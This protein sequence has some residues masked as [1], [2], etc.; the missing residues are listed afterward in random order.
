MRLT[1]LEFFICFVSVSVGFMHLSIIPESKEALKQ[2]CLYPWFCLRLN[3]LVFSGCWYSTSDW[4]S[5]AKQRMWKPSSFQLFGFELKA[6]SLCVS[7]LH[8]L[9][10]Y[11]Y[12]PGL[13]QWLCILVCLLSSWR[14]VYL[15][16]CSPVGGLTQAYMSLFMF[17]LGRFTFWRQFS[18]PNC[19]AQAFGPVHMCTLDW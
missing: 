6:F 7:S 11:F 14:F 18:S 13:N 1:Y 4:G 3:L 5:I 17:C 15:C 2:C 19:L 8:R 12:S 9:L 16:A 10:L